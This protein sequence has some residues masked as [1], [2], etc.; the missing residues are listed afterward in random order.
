MKGKYNMT[1]ED[2]QDDIVRM[3]YGDVRIAQAFET[4]RA[5]TKEKGQP[6]VEPLKSKSLD[7]IK[8]LVKDYPDGR[9]EILDM[10][11]GENHTLYPQT[12]KEKPTTREMI[13]KW[14]KG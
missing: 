8:Y 13:R 2:I 5:R 4:L 11:T 12:I 14:I 3:D 1:I 9:T 7:Y 6:Y 10:D